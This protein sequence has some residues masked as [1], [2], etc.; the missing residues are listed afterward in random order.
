M[1]ARRNKLEQHKILINNIILIRNVSTA[2]T[3]AISAPTGI[4]ALNVHQHIHHWLLQ[5]VQPQ[6]VY[7]VSTHLREQHHLA[8][9]RV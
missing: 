5:L 4:N 7:H 9:V 3:I 8:K 2:L 6:P 1:A